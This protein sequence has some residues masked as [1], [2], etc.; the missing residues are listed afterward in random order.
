MATILTSPGTPRA[1]RRKMAVVS[2]RRRSRSSPWLLA[3]LLAAA[4]VTHL[5]A[6][7]RYVRIVPPALPAPGALVALSGVAE[8]ACAV[9]VAMPR[10]RRIGGWATVALLVAVFPANVQMALDSGGGAGWYRTVAWLRV[11]LQVPLVLWAATVARRQRR[12]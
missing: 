11:P 6:P 7:E 12:T 9:L 8:L 1:D 4:G 5:V 10:T 2:T 3:G